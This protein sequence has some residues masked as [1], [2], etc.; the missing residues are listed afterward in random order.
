MKW[1]HLLLISTLFA[2]LL[3]CQDTTVH[4]IEKEEN[5]T[6]NELATEQFIRSHLLTKEG[7][8]QTDVQKRANV[9]LSESL[10]LWMLYLV[11]SG[12]EKEFD[13]QVNLLQDH[14]LDP[15]SLV[16]WEI[17]EGKPS[18]VNAWIDDA[19]IMRALYKAAHIFDHPEYIEIAKEIGESLNDYAFEQ[20][21]P[22][23][24]VDIPT[25]AKSSIITISY[26][27]SEALDILQQL[28]IRSTKDSNS[29]R[30]WVQ[31][32]P[33][34]NGFYPKSFNTKSK[35]FHYDKEINLIDQLYV[36][37]HLEQANVSTDH[38]ASWVNQ[39]FKKEKKL[40]G[41]YHFETKIPSVTYESPAVYSLA[42]LYSVEREDKE[43]ALQYYH[44][45]QSLSVQNKERSEYGGY[46]DISQQ[47]THSFDNLL[48]LLAERTL[49][50][51]GYI[52]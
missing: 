2:T 41:R 29:L 31:S 5:Y 49:L 10:G 28:Q 40:V 3:G 39:E 25:K 43:Q 19:R 20:K 48:P 11:E 50:N 46:I 23:D 8:I 36:A 16:Y 7:F 21:W 34:Q 38:F 12:R 1:G 42:I 37:Y 52:Q 27:D 22:V 45:M 32:I 17:T 14:F 35:T 13:Q 51:E 6:T 24:Y 33:V 4:P 26:L 18:K 47:Q 9:F 44:A 30:K 15:S